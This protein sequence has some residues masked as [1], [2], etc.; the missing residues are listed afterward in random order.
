[1]SGE[2][3]S[4]I[5]PVLDEAAYIGRLLRHLLAHGGTAV[6]EII[7]VDGGST[8]A[9][10]DIVSTFD[11]VALLSMNGTADVACRATQMNLGAAHA[12]GSILWFVHADT[13]PPATFSADL[14]HAVQRGK[15]IGGY[16][17]DF[18]SDRF[19]LRVNSWFTRF[20][21]SFTRGGDQTLFI[22]R[23]AWEALEG[24]GAHFVVME[25]YDLIDR[26]AAMGYHYHRLKGA[27]KVSARKYDANS[28]MQVQRANLVVFKMYRAGANPEA[29]KACYYKL[30]KHPKDGAHAE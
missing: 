28:Y 9:T 30:L 19:L 27:V 29:I 7:V 18:E 13:L 23:A 6:C 4:V 11:Q 2:Q 3:I 16:A 26:A 10:A 17:F 14:L 1:M 20:N 15:V 21:W 5:I 25:E 8:D 22:T 24:Y 12:K